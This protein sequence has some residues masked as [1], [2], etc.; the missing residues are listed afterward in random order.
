MA[1]LKNFFTFLLFA[2]KTAAKPP[3][4]RVILMAGGFPM[5][6]YRCTCCLSGG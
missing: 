1:D 2:A 4:V 5:R 6:I 3:D